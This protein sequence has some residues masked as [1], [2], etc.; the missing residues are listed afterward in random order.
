MRRPKASKPADMATVP[1]RIWPDEAAKE[2]LVSFM[3]QFQAAK[4]TAY[5]ALRRGKEPMPD[6]HRPC[7]R[8]QHYKGRPEE[9]DSISVPEG[10]FQGRDGA[11]LKN[12]GRRFQGI[13]VGETEEHPQAGRHGDQESSDGQALCGNYK[14]PLGHLPSPPVELENAICSW[15]L[16]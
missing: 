7:Q 11:C 5:Q 12:S 4:C 8:N 15:S 16:C 9:I 13:G 2:K 10:I 3:R 6:S 14:P 1:A